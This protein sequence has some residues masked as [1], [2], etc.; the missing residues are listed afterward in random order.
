[1]LFRSY[2]THRDGTPQ[3]FTIL[4]TAPAKWHP[5]DSYWYERFEHNREGAA[6]LGTYT[7]GGTVVTVGTTD[8]SHGLAGA[9]PTV[10]RI[11]RNILDRLVD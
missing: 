5:D 4:A 1:M 3:G 8:W 11:T 10:E 9:D 7:R 6:V 2:P